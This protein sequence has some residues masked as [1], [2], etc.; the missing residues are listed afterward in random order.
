MV[1]VPLEFTVAVPLNNPPVISAAL[2]RDKVYETEVPEAT[3]E[4]VSVKVA[5]DPSL[6]LLLPT[7]KA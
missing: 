6:T 7:L 5:V 1:A 4:V 2:T 3:F